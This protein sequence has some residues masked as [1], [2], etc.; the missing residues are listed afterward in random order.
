MGR[1]RIGA[2]HLVTTLEGGQTIAIEITLGDGTRGE[3]HAYVIQ[4]AYAESLQCRRR[5]LNPQR[6]KTFPVV[7]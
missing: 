2:Q 4:I 3:A 6:W 1:K 5:E 7:P